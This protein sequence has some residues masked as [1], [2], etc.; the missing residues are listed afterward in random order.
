MSLFLSFQFKGAR[1]IYGPSRSQIAFD[2][3]LDDGIRLDIGEKLVLCNDLVSSGFEEE[4]G[5]SKLKREVV[6]Y[7]LNLLKLNGGREIGAIELI[8][9][10]G[11]K[12]GWL[13]FRLFLGSEE[14]SALERSLDLANERATT[15][16]IWLKESEKLE[17][18]SPVSGSLSQ[19][20]SWTLHPFFN[21]SGTST[22]K[23]EIESFSIDFDMG[24]GAAGGGFGVGETESKDVARVV[25]LHTTRIAGLL[26]ELLV[27]ARGV[28][29]IR[30]NLWILFAGLAILLILLK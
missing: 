12:G 7:K 11:K 8:P 13:D 5:H 1:K 9:S 10:Y 3:R 21:W 2:V 17:R 15:I 22:E 20:Y 28:E 29:K 23:L 18:H 6:V 24:K 4:I 30:S 27:A 16:S 19:H 26:E 14:F 25:E